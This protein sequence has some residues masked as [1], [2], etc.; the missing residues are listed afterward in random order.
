MEIIT[1]DKKIQQNLNRSEIQEIV[2][3]F[4]GL[5][6]S[7]ILREIRQAFPQQKHLDKNLDFLVDHQVLLRQNRRYQ[8]CLNT[9]EA[10]PTI[11]KVEFFLHDLSADYTT[12][13]L[14]VWLGEEAWNDRLEKTMAIDFPLA[15]RNHLENEH[16]RIVTINRGGD[17]TATLPNYF[18]NVD[19]PALFPELATL[20]GDVNPEFFMNQIELVFDRVLSGRAPRRESIFLKSL[21]ASGMIVSQPEWQMLIPVYEEVPS[22]DW[23]Q[24]LDSDSRFFFARQLAERLLDK[25]ESFTY[26]IKKKT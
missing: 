1:G 19:E 11:E 25:H 23:T 10:N 3:Y 12:E 9:I 24:Q 26:L 16:F 17:L 5:N 7:V 2:S 22:L 6:E 15:F 4:Q 13:Q 20:I 8:F 21:L 18:S 14:L